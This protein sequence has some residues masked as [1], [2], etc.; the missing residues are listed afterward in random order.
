MSPEQWAA[1]GSALALVAAGVLKK[2]RVSI[3]PRDKP[4]EG[5][6]SPA[7]A[8]GA[9]RLSDPLPLGRGLLESFKRDV[10]EARQEDMGAIHARF[11]ELIKAH[12]ANLRTLQSIERILTSPSS[13]SQLTINRGFQTLARTLES[14]LANEESNK[15]D[16]VTV[17]A[18]LEELR[19][20]AGAGRGRHDRSS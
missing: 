15:A 1:L 8:T 10:R 14:M 18:I 4:G 9:V 16:L 7:T 2:F 20:A 13:A 11:D 12:D 6:D 5:D 17:L 19:G 3:E